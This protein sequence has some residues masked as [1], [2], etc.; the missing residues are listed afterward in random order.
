SFADSP[1]ASVAIW[2]RYLSYGAALGV[3]R[4]AVA[5]LPMGSESDD[6][7]WS[8]QSGRWRLVHI[9]YRNW[10]PGWGRAPGQ[11]MFSGVLTA[12]VAGGGSAGVLYVLIRLV[13]AGRQVESGTEE[14]RIIG[15]WVLAGVLAIAMFW[16]VSSLVWLSYAVPDLKARAQIRGRLLRIHENR[17]EDS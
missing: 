8:K 7:A 2:Q 15:L 4:A 3:A 14:F 17:T 6:E 13:V 9:S 5:A 11:V 1:V 12:I 10:P 16:F